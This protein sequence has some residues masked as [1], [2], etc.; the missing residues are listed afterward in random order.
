MSSYVIQRQSRGV[1]AIGAIDLGAPSRAG[2]G[3]VTSRPQI[4]AAKRT[5]ARMP[6][7]R[8]NT[9]V[10]AN[11]PG[12]RVLSRAALPSSPSI[13]TPT[14]QV[15]PPPP[16]GGGISTA[17]SNA[18]DAANRIM[19]ADQEEAMLE[20]P[21]VSSRKTWLILG[22]LGVAGLGAYLYWRKR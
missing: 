10:S 4:Q 15:G 8:T 5:A 9:I 17:V 16:S 18:R 12:I 3:I 7:P 6:A 21:Q 13:A 11:R 20:V 2:G 19:E 14:F 22:A 1:G